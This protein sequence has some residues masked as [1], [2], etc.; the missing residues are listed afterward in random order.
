MSV[1]VALP[2]NNVT[3]RY[4]GVAG[5]LFVILYVIPALTWGGIRPDQPAT[6]VASEL[7]NHRGAAVVSA[8]LLL[9]GSV[10]LLVFAAGMSRAA[11]GGASTRNLS[12]IAFG[13][14]LLSAA[15]LAVANA[16]LGALGG[17][18]ITGSAAETIRALNGLWDGLSTVS[19][20][21]L[22]VFA[23]AVSL[24]AFDTRMLARW[25]R[26]LG[27][28]AGVV[29]IIGSGSLATPFRGPGPFWILGLVGTSCGSH[30]RVSGC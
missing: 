3:E 11:A 15:L 30:Q 9:A 2:S 8:Y 14:G 26:W 22:G 13:A 27:V 28:V 10:A 12:A 17:Y 18:I 16:L 4:T 20:L 19:G 29:L 7:I 21:F 25:M 5:I 23:I 1:D 24:L 6:S